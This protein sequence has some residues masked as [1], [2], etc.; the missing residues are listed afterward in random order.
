MIIVNKSGQI[1]ILLENLIVL[2]EW[3]FILLLVFIHDIHL[4]KTFGSFRLVY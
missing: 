2:L 3:I 4:T 1:E